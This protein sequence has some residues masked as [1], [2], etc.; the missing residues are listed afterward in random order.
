M[1]D[2]IK[3]TYTGR[4]NEKGLLTLYNRGI[5]IDEMNTF[6]NCEVQLTVQ[7]KG[8]LRSSKSNRFYWG[9]ILTHAAAALIEIAPDLHSNIQTEDVHELFKQKFEY[10]LPKV[11]NQILDVETGD[12]V[13]IDRTTTKAKSFLFVPYLEACIQFCIEYLNIKASKFDSKEYKRLKLQYEKMQS[14]EV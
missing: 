5:F 6:R 3:L 10:L 9:C 7:K 12:I 2:N 13:S 1:Q 8:R 11:Q 14:M 4:V